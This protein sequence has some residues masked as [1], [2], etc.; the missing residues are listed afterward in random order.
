MFKKTLDSGIEESIGESS[1]MSVPKKK[2]ETS[3]DKD[4]YTDFE[5]SASNSN[6]AVAARIE[7]AKKKAAEDTYESSYSASYSQ[8]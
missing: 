2:E 6:S 8:S 5:E 4:S 3:P 7:A 1:S